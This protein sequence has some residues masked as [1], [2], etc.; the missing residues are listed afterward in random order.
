M[1]RESRERSYRWSNYS[2]FFHVR[3]KTLFCTK[4]CFFCR[5]VETYQRYLCRKLLKPCGNIVCSSGSST[6][7]WS[8]KY[9]IGVFVAS[10]AQLNTRCP[11]KYPIITHC[12]ITEF[13]FLMPPNSMMVE[14]SSLDTSHNTA[15]ET[16]ILC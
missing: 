7:R 8:L 15:K 10:T 3:K 5:A 6:E 13:G 4:A 1:K 14:L 12:I 9:F 11:T 2:T 16:C